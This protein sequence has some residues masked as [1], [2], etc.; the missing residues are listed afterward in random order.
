MKSKGYSLSELCKVLE[1]SRSGLYAHAAKPY[2]P[3]RH[4]DHI[5]ATQIGA[6]FAQSRA[7]YGTRRIQV[8]L[9]RLGHA[10][11]RRRISR[12]MV[13]SGLRP[14]QKRRFNPR[15]TNSRHSH[16]I[17]PNHLRA[18]EQPLRNIPGTVWVSDITYIQTHEGWLYLAAEMDLASRYIV[19]WMTSDSLDASLVRDAFKRAARWRKLPQLHHSDRGCQYAAD[20]FRSLLRI[21]RVLPSMSRKAN[22][23]DNAAMESFWATL[24]A[25]CFGRYV[26]ATR[27]QANR[28]IFDYIESFYNTRRLH[29]SLGYLSPADFEQSFTS[30]TILN[31]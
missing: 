23:Y 5:L 9:N 8:C 1:V 19:G 26:P 13:S 27:K 17:A 20:S 22:C 29:S 31:N 14:K 4:K 7:T 3:R 12:I 2:R 6:L 21:H 25:E 18:L 28:M 30:T 10:H 11:G 16:P 24:K 15:T